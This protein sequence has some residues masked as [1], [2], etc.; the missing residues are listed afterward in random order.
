[1]ESN[2]DVVCLQEVW[3][4]DL[5]RQIFSDL[6][7]MYPHHVS[8][9]DLTSNNVAMTPVCSL[10]DVSN[11]G[12]CFSSNCATST[13]VTCPITECLDVLLPFSR[14]CRLCLFVNLDITTC[15]IEPFSNY[16]TTFGLMLFSKKPMSN[17]QSR[18]YLGEL[19]D[20]RGF[21]QATVCCELC[22]NTLTH[23]LLPCLIA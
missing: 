22:V 19:S 15:T 1:M 2:L 17:G 14:E 10:Q 21:Y 7:D 5:Q 18:G 4:T 20:S 6:R 9:I 13:E 16:E 23:R 12:D 11:F 8:H 3:R